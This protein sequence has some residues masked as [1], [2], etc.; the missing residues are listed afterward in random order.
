MYL[1]MSWKLQFELMS[2]LA[3]D[4]LHFKLNVAYLELR[5]FF[6]KIN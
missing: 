3:D 5:E 1:S 6:S 2:S 4:T